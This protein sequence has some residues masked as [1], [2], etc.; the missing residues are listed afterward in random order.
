MVKTEPHRFIIGIGSQRAGSTLMHRLLEASSNVFMH[1]LKELHYFDTLYGYRSRQAL[2]DFSMRQIMREID[3]IVSSKDLGFVKNNRYRCY[4]RTNRLLSRSPI[5][6]INYI[7]L[8]RP[9]LKKHQ[10]LGEVTP[11]YMLFDDDSIVKMQSVIGENAGIILIC[12]DPVKRF[13]STVKLMSVYNRLQLDDV[14][15]NDWIRQMLDS[16]NDWLKA[17]DSYNDYESAIDRYSRHFE[18]FLAIDY[19][20]LI[21]NPKDV[22]KKVAKTLGISLDI[23]IF[24]GET[25]GVVNSLGKDFSIEQEI[26]D[27]ISERYRKSRE[28]MNEYFH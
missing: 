15:A 25:R 13:L 17:Q 3:R 23:D 10:L 9:N 7:E 5:E 18:N 1:P 2:Q 26:V 12:R 14:A 6:K 21:N 20:D 27:R 16:D 11:E 28:F 24:E 8:F 19:D 4:L 22:A